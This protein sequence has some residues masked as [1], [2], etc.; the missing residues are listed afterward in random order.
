ML[1]LVL[2]EDTSSNHDTDSKAL[3]PHTCLDDLLRHRLVA[4][5]HDDGAG[6]GHAG[7]PRAEDDLVLVVH[8]PLLEPVCARKRLPVLLLLGLD[9]LELADTDAGPRRLVELDAAALGLDGVGGEDDDDGGEGLELDGH[10]AEGGPFLIGDVAC[11]EGD[12]Q[13]GEQAFDGTADGCVVVAL[14]LFL[15]SKLKD[16]VSEEYC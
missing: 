2:C 8:R 12:G 4:V 15:G 16:I 1:A 13:T 10:G 6:D 11:R 3:G 9:A 5:G 14:E 7:G